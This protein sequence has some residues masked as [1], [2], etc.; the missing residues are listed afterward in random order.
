MVKPGYSNTSGLEVSQADTTAALQVASDVMANK[1]VSD[2]AVLQST[3]ALLDACSGPTIPATTQHGLIALIPRLETPEQRAEAI[4][5]LVAIGA[6]TQDVVDNLCQAGEDS[7]LDGVLSPDEHSSLR[8]CLVDSLEQRMAMIAGMV[9]QR[10]PAPAEPSQT[11]QH[12]AEQAMLN[13][14]RTELVE[15]DDIRGSAP[16]DMSS[17]PEQGGVTEAGVGEDMS[18]GDEAIPPETRLAAAV[19]QGAEAIGELENLLLRGGQGQEFAYVAMM[20]LGKSPATR[21]AVHSSARRMEA[22][23]AIRPVAETIRRHV[24]R[25]GT[26]GVDAARN[27]GAAAVGN[28]WLQRALA[29]CD[30]PSIMKAAVGR[31][32]MAIPL[33]MRT[34]ASHGTGASRNR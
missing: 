31:E 20:H 11:Y 16:P 24:E 21:R 30:S 2:A 4:G 28:G 17:G 25:G 13:A 33:A 19:E 22:N 14:Q 7:P 23:E 3:R 1:D 27:R 8:N 9:G 32:A 18:L 10:A 5:E 6:N 26:A 12:P 34:L 29:S 15:T